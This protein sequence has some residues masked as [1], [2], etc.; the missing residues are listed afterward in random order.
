MTQNAQRELSGILFRNN[1]KEQDKHPDFTGSATIEG[2]EY[3]ISAWVKEGPKAKFFSL[4][5]KPKQEKQEAA[6]PAAPKPAARKS[7][8]IDLDDEIPF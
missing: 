4:A 1:R 8:A 2:V 6:P 3:Y 5:F 7:Y